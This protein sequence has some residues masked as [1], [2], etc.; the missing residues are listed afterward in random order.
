MDDEEFGETVVAIVF[1]KQRGGRGKK[2]YSGGVVGKE[3]YLFASA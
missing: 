3:S 1:K 2:V